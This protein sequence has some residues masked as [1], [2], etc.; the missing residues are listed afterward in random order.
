MTVVRLVT[1]TFVAASV[2]FSTAAVLARDPVAPPAVIASGKAKL[3]A[4][5]DKRASKGQKRITEAADDTRKAE[6][7]KRKGEDR[8]AEGNAKVTTAQEAYKRYLAGLT[9]A[10]DP[11]SAFAQADGLRDTAKRWEDALN[12][13]RDGEKDIRKAT[14]DLASAVRSKAEGEAMLAEGNALK[15]QAGGVPL[16]PVSVVQPKI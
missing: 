15:A 11:K 16:L 5:G 12:Q 8:I 4:D 2:L 3:W 9:A 14:D 10:A 6:A 13:V 1:A 7:R